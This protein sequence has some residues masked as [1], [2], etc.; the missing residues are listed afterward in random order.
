MDSVTRNSGIALSVL[1][2]TTASILLLLPGKTAGSWPG[3][4]A[5]GHVVMASAVATSAW[6]TLG[7]Q[8]AASGRNGG[9]AAAGPRPG[10]RA[11]GTQSG[12]ARAGLTTVR[13]RGARP[14]AA[15]ARSCRPRGALRDRDMPRR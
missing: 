6:G 15:R 12:R 3:P 2:A 7:S 8:P 13:P 1:I 10:C 5:P 14:G 11:A 9:Q 4:G